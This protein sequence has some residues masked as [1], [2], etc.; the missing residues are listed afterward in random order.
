MFLQYFYLKKKTVKSISSKKGHYQKL[1]PS[2]TPTHLGWRLN[3][4]GEIT[5]SIVVTIVKCQIW[6]SQ[7]KCDSLELESN[8]IDNTVPSQNFSEHIML[9]VKQTSKLNLTF[10]NIII[11]LQSQINKH[12]QKLSQCCTQ[13]F[14]GHIGTCTQYV[15]KWTW[16]APSLTSPGKLWIL[17]I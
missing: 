14:F 6:E 5:V 10:E 17:S 2:K 7:L 8:I 12:N 1:M 13:S 15:L 4:F 3:P 11:G 16:R 9:P